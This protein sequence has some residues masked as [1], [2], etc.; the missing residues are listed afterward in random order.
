[1]ESL[2]VDR[3]ASLIHP[4]DRDRVMNKANEVAAGQSDDYYDEFRVVHPNG[5]VLWLTSQGAVIRSENGLPKWMAG[6]NIDISEQKAADAALRESEALFRNMAETAPVMI[7]IADENQ[8]TNYINKQMLDFLGASIAQMKSFGWTKFIHQDDKDRVLKKYSDAFNDRSSFENEYRIRRNDGEYRWLVSRGI[9]RFR[10]DGKFLGY[11]G[12]AFD[13][14]ERK[15]SQ[16]ELQETLEEL[17]QLKNQL[18][19]ENIY[20]QHEI[21]QGQS[22]GDIVGQSAAIKYVLFKVSQVSRTDAS[23]LVTGETETRKGVGSQG[24]PRGQQSP[25]SAVDKG[26]LRGFD[27]KLDRKRTFGHERGSFTRGGRPENWPIRTGKWRYA[28]AG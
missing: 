5:Q 1:M 13:I 18:E 19:A 27:P 7:W 2:T 4:D 14:T 24:Y 23:V 26:E 6:V 8:E 28:S 10:P 16:R 11:I 12:T 20:L 17:N 22:F 25:R 15:E 21:Q 9:P 3:F